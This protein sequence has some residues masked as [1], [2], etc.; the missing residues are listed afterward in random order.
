MKK[1]VPYFAF[2]YIGIFMIVSFPSVT[3]AC[4]CVELP[5]V[6]EEMDRSKAVFSG[7]V[8]GI[9]EKRSLKGDTSTSVLFDVTKTWK[10]V[11]QSQIIINTGLSNADCGFDF[12]EGQEYLVYAKESTMYGAKSLVTTICDRTNGFDASKEDLKIL[13]GGTPPTEKAD[14]SGTFKG[15]PYRIWIAGLFMAI[16]IVAIFVLRGRKKHSKSTL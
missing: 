4:S 12:T 9:K 15:N 11:R 10:G 3:S 8:V 1:I 7:K 14:L 13:G 5:S 2:I 6:K 16:G